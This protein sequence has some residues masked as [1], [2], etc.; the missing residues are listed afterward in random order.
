MHKPLSVPPEKKNV[1]RGRLLN[2]SIHTRDSKKQIRAAEAKARKG[3]VEMRKRKSED[4]R[5][6][7]FN[8]PEML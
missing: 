3:E 6:G 1:G 7:R 2:R 4:G 5:D 8:F